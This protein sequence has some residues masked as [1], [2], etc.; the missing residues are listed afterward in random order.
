MT[1]H[2]CTQ[3][4]IELIPSIEI[5]AE[6]VLFNYRDNTDVKQRTISSCHRPFL[7]NTSCP[8]CCSCCTAQD[9]KDCHIDS[10][11]LH[12]PVSHL[13]GDKRV[14]P[15]RHAK[16]QCY[17]I[18]LQRLES[19]AQFSYNGISHSFY[20]FNNRS[21]SLE[22]FNQAEPLPTL[23]VSPATLAESD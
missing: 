20:S 22:L 10:G 4:E 16:A 21:N 19:S 12:K 5:C 17:Q 3:L 18:Y 23:L 2:L 15:H 6:L 14:D 8:Q 9:I 1:F 13:H 7:V 11:S